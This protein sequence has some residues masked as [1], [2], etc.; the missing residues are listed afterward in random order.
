MNNKQNKFFRPPRDFKKQNTFNNIP[1]KNN[2]L[3]K[4]KINYSL[5]VD[6][7]LIKYFYKYL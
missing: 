4:D 6:G 7:N 3:S 5:K 2:L 1:L